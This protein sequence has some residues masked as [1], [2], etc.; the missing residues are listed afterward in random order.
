[1]RQ[2]I[3]AVFLLVTLISFGSSAI[4]VQKAAAEGLHRNRQPVGMTGSRLRKHDVQAI[5]L[6]GGGG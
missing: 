6:H 1:M 4:S 2:L 5:E 3:F